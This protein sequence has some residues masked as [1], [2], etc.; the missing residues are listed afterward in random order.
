VTPRG[1]PFTCGDGEELEETDADG[2]ASKVSARSIAVVEAPAWSPDWLGVAAATTGVFGD[3]IELRPN[4]PHAI[5]SPTRIPMPRVRTGR[6]ETRVII[7]SVART[8]H[9]KWRGVDLSFSIAFFK[10]DSIQ[11][12]LLNYLPDAAL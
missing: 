9:R 3:P 8:S 4:T 1:R 10:I 11:K 12:M 5:R 2:F 7:L 6:S